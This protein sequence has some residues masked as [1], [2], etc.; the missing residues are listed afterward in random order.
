VRWL[1]ARQPD[2]PKTLPGGSPVKPRPEQ[3]RA[4]RAQ[5]AAIARSRSRHLGGVLA[6]Q[7]AVITASGV[8]YVDR[9]DAPQELEPEKPRPRK[10]RTP[11]AKND[12]KYVAAARELRD[13]YLEQV[14]TGRMLPAANGKYDV[15]RQLEAPPSTMVIE[16]MPMLEAA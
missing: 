12:P 6:G 9:A 4:T 2:V 1:P 15:S 3:P 5:A 16:Q 7:A 8:R 11:R 14:N 10:P 13:R